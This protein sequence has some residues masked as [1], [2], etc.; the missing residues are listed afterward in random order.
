MKIKT[1]IWQKIIVIIAIINILDSYKK[2]LFIKVIEWSNYMDK[3]IV[4]KM[5][6]FIG[7]YFKPFIL[8]NIPTLI[9]F[10][11][12]FL[13]IFTIIDIRNKNKKSNPD[14]NFN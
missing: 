13:L 6:Y 8:K 11:L 5:G 9:C 4:Y 2:I 12:L 14:S 1:T 10:G 3:S 7:F